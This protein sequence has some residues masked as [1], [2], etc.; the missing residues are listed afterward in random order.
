MSF[1]DPQKRRNWQREYRRRQ[2]RE[3]YLKNKEKI[4]ERNRKYWAANKEKVHSQQRFYAHGITT[5]QFQEMLIEQNGL[6]ALCHKPMTKPYIDHHHETG[7]I[8]GLLHS[9]CNVLLGMEEDDPVRCEEAA[10]YLRKFQGDK[11]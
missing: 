2:A 3:R 10:L 8:R 11:K 4:R 9:N 5:E 6:C 7:K 1:S